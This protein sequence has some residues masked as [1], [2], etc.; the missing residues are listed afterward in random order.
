MIGNKIKSTM[1]LDPPL[2]LT[3]SDCFLL[4]QSADF[5]LSVAQLHLGKP[6]SL[7]IGLRKSSPAVDGATAAQT[8]GQ[9]N[10]NLIRTAVPF[11]CAHECYLVQ[12]TTQVNK[13]KQSV[14]E[15]Q[16]T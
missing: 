3:S 8:L 5:L 1:V 6:E 4:G 14:P 16:P 11:E 12:I 10:K 7:L 15:L 2:L 13:A 9:C